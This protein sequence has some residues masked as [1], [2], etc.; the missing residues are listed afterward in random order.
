MKKVKKDTIDINRLPKKPTWYLRPIIVV[1]A[2]FAT[3]FSK[4]KVNKVNCENLKWPYILICSH[5]AFLDFIMNAKMTFPHHTSYICS[6]EEFVGREWLMRGIGA[7]P[8]RKYTKDIRVVKNCL[9][10][11]KKQKNTLSIYAEARYSPSGTNERIDGA[12][13]KLAKTANVPVVMM[14]THGNFLHQPQWD[15]KHPRNLRYEI[16][17]KCIATQEEVE[18]LSAEEIQKRIV[19]NFVYDDYKWQYENKIKVKSKYRANNLHNLLYK[20]PH[21]GKDYAMDSKHTHLWCKECGAK[22]EMDVYGRLHCLTGEGKFEHVPDWYRW[23]REEVRKEV[24]SGTYRFED[25]VRIEK[26]SVSSKGFIPL[27]HVKFVQD[28]DGIHLHGTLDN[29]EEFHFD[30]DPI[31][32]PSIHID[33]NFKKRGVLKRGHTLDID[34]LNDTWYIYPQTENRVVTKIHL[35]TEALYDRAERELKK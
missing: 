10:V 15:Q 6:I 20:C 29:G 8:K 4:I 26:L 28:I 13:G 16:D 1:G 19:D 33:Y 5:A 14:I 3:L 25:T 22:Y 12:M 21:C 9:H 24:E 17:F 30:N 7:F 35:A 34:T 11:L 23:E 18:T 31:N 27:G 2:F 32:T